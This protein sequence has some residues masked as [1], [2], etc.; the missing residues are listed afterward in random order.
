MLS[1]Q[2]LEKIDE[3]EANLEVSNRYSEGFGVK[4]DAKKAADAFHR[5]VLAGHPVALAVAYIIQNKPGNY[6]KA[7]DILTRSA[8]RNHPSGLPFSLDHSITRS[9]DH[10]IV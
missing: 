10:S 6:P 4:A 8:E 3:P 1:L 9:F 2:E 7:L 5:A